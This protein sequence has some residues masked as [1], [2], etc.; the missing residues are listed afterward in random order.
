M[1]RRVLKDVAAKYRIEME[2]P[3]LIFVT[4]ANEDWIHKFAS[5]LVDRVNANK[6]KD[7]ES[8]QGVP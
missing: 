4:E 6:S 3:D 7:V 8:D 5:N 1:P 2:K